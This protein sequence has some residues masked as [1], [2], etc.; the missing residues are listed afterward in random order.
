MFDFDLIDSR[1]CG[2]GENGDEAMHVRVEVQALHH[3]SAVGFE[4]TALIVDRNLGD[5]ADQPVGEPG[6]QEPKD[7]AILSIL[8][9]ATDH[10]GPS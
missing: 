5:P 6:R 1:T 10:I 9:P 3:L 4:R 8:S 2:H 7:K